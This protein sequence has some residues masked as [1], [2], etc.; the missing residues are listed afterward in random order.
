ML[1][2]REEEAEPEKVDLEKFERARQ[3]Q[4][5]RR[6]QS[7]PRSRFLPWEERNRE[8]EKNREDMREESKGDGY[9]ETEGEEGF[10]SYSGMEGMGIPE[11]IMEEKRR[12]GRKATVE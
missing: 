6:A 1:D 3:R 8:K 11:D 9:K 4:E 5:E 7:G 2:A 10:G 12:K